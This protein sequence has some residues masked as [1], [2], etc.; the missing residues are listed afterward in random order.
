[1]RDPD[2]KSRRET[3]MVEKDRAA[4]VAERME[5]VVGRCSCEGESRSHSGF[6]RSKATR[7]RPEGEEVG[8]SH[9]REEL[10]LGKRNR[11]RS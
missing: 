9:D 5:L 7:L 6:E 1:L 3:G 8:L 2:P 4:V 11:V 10:G